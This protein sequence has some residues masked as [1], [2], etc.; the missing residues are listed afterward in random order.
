M[1]R[2]SSARPK[3]TLTDA[4]QYKRFAE[5][6]REVE[7]DERSASFDRAFAKVVRVRPRKAPKDG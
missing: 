4:D 5:I 6:A 7:V 2:K 3:R 1:P